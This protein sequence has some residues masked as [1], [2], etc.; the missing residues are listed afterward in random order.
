MRRSGPF[1]SP[2]HRVH[3]LSSPK[4]PFISGSNSAVTL[5]P[6]GFFKNV[7][8]SYK[9]VHRQQDIGERRRDIILPPD[10]LTTVGRWKD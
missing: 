9:T 3:L 4:I 8:R 2:V 1:F 5:P 10:S 6:H 7:T